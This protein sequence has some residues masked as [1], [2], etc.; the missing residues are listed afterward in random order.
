[1]LL[2]YSFYIP[3][4]WAEEAEA[5]T[6]VS[7]TPE[8]R[9]LRGLLKQI[10]LKVLRQQGWSVERIEGAG[11]ASVRRISRGNDTMKISIRT[12]QDTWIAFPWDKVKNQWVTLNDVDVVLAVSVDAAREP[13]FANVHWLPGKD[14]RDRFNRAHRARIA[15]GHS[16]PEGRGVWVSLYREESSDP[17]SNVGAGAGLAFPPI[18]R[19]SLADAVTTDMVPSAEGPEAKTRAIAHA[20]EQPLTIPEAKRRLAQTLG[21][22][23]E[24]IKITVEA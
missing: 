5:M 8:K 1:L 14:L 24:N 13:K 9:R 22:D 3:I 2:I 17:V 7:K 23:P 21:V 19:V 16:I 15:A 20:D 18:A 11:K 6:N 10:G 4:L 12:T